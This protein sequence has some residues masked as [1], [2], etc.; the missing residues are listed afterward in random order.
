MVLCFQGRPKERQRDLSEEPLNKQ[1]WILY[2][3]E[4]I[5]SDTTHRCNAKQISNFQ[6]P[7]KLNSIVS[8]QIYYKEKHCVD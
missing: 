1:R 6:S 7:F 5:S 3:K 8:C 2:T 4:K